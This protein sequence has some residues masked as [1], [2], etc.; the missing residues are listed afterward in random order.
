VQATRGE[1]AEALGFEE[2]PDGRAG[3]P[4]GEPFS[5]GRTQIE[6]TPLGEFP[7]AS[8]ASWH[9][10]EVNHV[11]RGPPPPP[12]HQG[13]IRSIMNTVTISGIQGV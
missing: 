13:E 6:K 2:I 10:V 8:L 5:L 9:G 3:P 1:V 12:F 4:C 7:V 11:A